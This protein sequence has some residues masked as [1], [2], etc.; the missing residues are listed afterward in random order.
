M[1]LVRKI[2]TSLDKRFEKHPIIGFIVY[3]VITG[4]AGSLALILLLLG[5]LVLFGIYS[6][7]DIDYKTWWLFIIM[8]S[9]LAILVFVYGAMAYFPYRR[10][11]NSIFKK[12][13]TKGTSYRAL[14]HLLINQK[15][16]RSD[17]FGEN[18]I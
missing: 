3:G 6:R 9:V 4:F 14:H 8:A 11:G 15:N 1:E 10:K 13:Y 16:E 18:K 7:L 17:F 5:I 2:K 12:E